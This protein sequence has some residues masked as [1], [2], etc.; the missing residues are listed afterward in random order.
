MPSDFAATAARLPEGYGVV[1]QTRGTPARLVILGNT[2]R[3]IQYGK[4]SADQLLRSNPRKKLPEV[5]LILDWPDLPT[6]CACWPGKGDIE[7]FLRRMVDRKQN[8]LTLIADWSDHCAGLI[9]AHG[10]PKPSIARLIKRATALNL[11]LDIELR[12]SSN[13]GGWTERSGFSGDGPADPHPLLRKLYR[14]FPEVRH[15][16]IY[17]TRD[18]HSP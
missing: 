14:A 1:L 11:G 13:D 15:Y 9:D 16:K 3:S 8:V 18:D 6:R 12:G 10:R 2:V 4:V 7:L 5:V 17:T